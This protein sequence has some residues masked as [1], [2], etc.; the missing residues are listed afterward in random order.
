MVVV[1]KSRYVKTRRLKNSDI[2]KLK[3]NVELPSDTN[4]IYLLSLSKYKKK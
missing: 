2:K 3:R 1:W 4:T